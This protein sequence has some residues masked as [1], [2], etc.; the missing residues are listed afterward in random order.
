MSTFDPADLLAQAAP[1]L[2]PTVKAAHLE[3]LRAELGAPSTTTLVT[4]PARPET[5]GE[6]GPRRRRPLAI[7]LAA[8]ALVG[9]GAGA[10]AA[11]IWRAEPTVTEIARCFATSTPADFEDYTKSGEAFFDIA[12]LTGDGNQNTTTDTAEHAVEACASAWRRGELSETSPHLLPLDPWYVDFTGP[13]PAEHAVPPLAA[14]VLESGIVG[15]IPNTTCAALRLPE[16]DLS[17]L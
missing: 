6:E 3:R 7:G 2:S 9:A 8:L 15:V 11:Y 10:A 14:C 4:D 1:E 13:K 12:V 5:G 17:R 16:A